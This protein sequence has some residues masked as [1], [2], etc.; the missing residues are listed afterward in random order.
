MSDALRNAISRE[1]KSPNQGTTL[2]YP[3]GVGM[4]GLILFI[5]VQVVLFLL[6]FKFGFVA[7][8]NHLEGMIYDGTALLKLPFKLVKI[9]PKKEEMPI[10]WRDGVE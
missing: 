3:G 2:G 4:I 7:G 10:G 6:A 9:E 8:Y 1:R 5:A